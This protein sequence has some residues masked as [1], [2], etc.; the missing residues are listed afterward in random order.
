[1]FLPIDHAP[2]SYIDMGAVKEKSSDAAGDHG[3]FTRF[4]IPNL[5]PISRA[6]MRA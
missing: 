5:Q 3:Y 1:M 4:S 2:I 6:G